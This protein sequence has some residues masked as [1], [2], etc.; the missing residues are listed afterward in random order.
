VIRLPTARIQKTVAIVATVLAAT[1]LCWLSWRAGSP[2]WDHLQAETTRQAAMLAKLR[3]PGNAPKAGPK[4][5][6]GMP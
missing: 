4:Q 1:A 5:R 2:L 6:I 3:I